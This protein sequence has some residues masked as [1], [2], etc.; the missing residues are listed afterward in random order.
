[1]AEGLYECYDAKHPLTKAQQRQCGSELLGY[2]RSQNLHPKSKDETFDQLG[3]AGGMS[4]GFAAYEKWGIGHEWRVPLW[5]LVFHD[6]IVSTWLY[7]FE[8]LRQ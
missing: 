6:C 4:G 3:R 7:L 8:N 5:E 2:V 1:M